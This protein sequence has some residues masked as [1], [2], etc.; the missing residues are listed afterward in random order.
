LNDGRG[1][2]ARSSPNSSKRDV[3]GRYRGSFGGL[4]WSFAQAALP[5]RRLHARLRRDP[6]GALGI[7]RRHGDYALMVFAG[8]IVFNAFAEC[9]NTAPTLIAANANYVKKV[10]FPLEVLPWVT[11]LTATFHAVIGIVVWLVGYAILY[12]APRPAALLFPAVSVRS[13]RVL[14]G[15]GWLLSALGV[16]VRDIGQLA[17]LASHALLF[18]TPIFYGVDAVPP[19][20]Q[21]VL[22]ANPLT[23]VVEQLRLVLFQGSRAE[24]ARACGLFRAGVRVRR[25]CR[26]RCSAACARASRRWCR[27]PRLRSAR[28]GSGKR[29][30]V[31]DDQRAAPAARAV[32]LLDPRHDGDLGAAGR[33]PG[34]GARRVASR[35][36]GATA[37][38][39]A[40]CCR[41]LA[42][43]RWPTTGEVAVNGRVSALLELGSGFN[44]E[45]TGRDNVMMNGLILGLTREEIAGRFGEIA[46]FAEIGDAIDRPVK[47]YSSGMLMRLAFAVQ[48]LT[49]PEILVIDEALSVGD[50]FFQ[51]KCLGYIRALLDKGVTL[52]FV[53]HDMGTV[54]EPV[55]SRAV[56]LRDGRVAFAGETSLAIHEYLAERGGA[57]DTAFARAG[58]AADTAELDAIHSRW[59][60]ARGRRAGWRRPD[61]R[62]GH[63]RRAGKAGDVFSHGRVDAHPRGLPSRAFG[64]HARD[65]VIRNKYD[66]VVT[67]IGSAQLNVTPPA[68][69][70][71]QPRDLRDGARLAAR[72]GQLFGDGGARA[73]A[74]APTTAATSIRRTRSGRSRSIGTTSRSARRSWACSA[75]ARLRDVQARR[76]QGA[77]RRGGKHEP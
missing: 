66:Q 21:N 53:S 70:E 30:R 55:P 14:L 15:I 63:L 65:A 2:I 41:L 12:G 13:S 26:W 37:A 5:A 3:S 62:R 36:S 25:C 28:A 8:L 19:L 48:V 71:W 50:F 45:Y 32:A 10:V 34:G 4:A 67:S 46:A 51:Q 57:A 29:Y 76:K 69:G 72:G 22:M 47:T 73:P 42:P 23:F 7:R 49:D 60:L 16:A 35:S 56:Y 59:P 33:R 31:Y 64:A 9:L 17:A 18:L 38:A 75:A 43:A 61:H 24:P 27:W 11:A 58:E 39:R 74:W 6:A 1:A 68:P 40:R 44:P 54:R 20:L 52:V 77:L